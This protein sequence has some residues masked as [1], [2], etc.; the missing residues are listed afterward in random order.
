MF[1]PEAFAEESEVYPDQLEGGSLIHFRIRPKNICYISTL[2]I[3]FSHRHLICKGDLR[4]R[5]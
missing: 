4:I 3:G 2:L 1:R 5:D